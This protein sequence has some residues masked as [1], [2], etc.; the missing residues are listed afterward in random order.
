MFTT[1]I[2]ARHRVLRSPRSAVRPPARVAAL[3]LTLLTSLLT[4]VAFAA[5]APAAPGATPATSS[6]LGTCAEGGVT[7][8]VDFTDLGGEVEVGC[9]IGAGTGTEALQQAGFTDTRDGAGMICA[10]NAQP[11]PCPAEFTGSFW[12]YWHGAETWV[13]SM[14]GSDTTTA[15][16]AVVEGWR[17]HDGSEGPTITPAE[18]VALAARSVA[19]PDGPAVPDGPTDAEDAPTTAA[20][21]DDGDD[22]D[23]GD[24]TSDEAADADEA[25]DAAGP[26]AAASGPSPLVVVGVALL[27]V[28]VVLA[29]AVARRR[30]TA[31]DG[32]ADG[33]ADR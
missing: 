12:S 16:S 30:A 21:G 27:V 4:A 18:A 20:A 8:V 17:Y 31:A 14:E 32:A 24:D 3:L 1:P 29:V 11:D 9:A 25:V 5:P 2:G 26:G 7:V 10:I 22:G 15:D 6:P 13:S 28:V 33:A 19:S 23:A